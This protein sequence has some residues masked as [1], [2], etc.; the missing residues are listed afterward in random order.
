VR[1]N[2][3]LTGREGGKG[4]LRAT[5]QVLTGLEKDRCANNPT[6][7]R[8]DHLCF[9]VVMARSVENPELEEEKRLRAVLLQDRMRLENT[10][11]FGAPR[12]HNFD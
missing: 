5:K 9:L 11:G 2:G 7:H 3:K 10:G 8:A 6:S 1:Y 4:I 12:W